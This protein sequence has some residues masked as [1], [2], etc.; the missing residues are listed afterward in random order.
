MGF[1]MW[2]KP[3]Q[4]APKMA[5]QRPKERQDEL[6]VAVT[7]QLLRSTETLQKTCILRCFRASG[8]PK[9]DSRNAQEA[10]CCQFEPPRSDKEDGMRRL[11]QRAPKRDRKRAKNEP[12]EGP[13]N[14]SEMAQKRSPKRGPKMACE[15]LLTSTELGPGVES[16]RALY[17]CNV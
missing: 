16:L 10:S 5:F 17:L 6:Q 2:P 11:R 3:A 15:G 1:K 9:S 12:Q 7:W 4:E 13:R 8:L 14:E